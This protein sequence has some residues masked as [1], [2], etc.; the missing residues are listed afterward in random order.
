VLPEMVTSRALVNAI[1][2][3]SWAASWATAV[4]AAATANSAVSDHEVGGK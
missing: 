2:R 4:A 1:G 3:R